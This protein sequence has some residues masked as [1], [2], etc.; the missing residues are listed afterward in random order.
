MADIGLFSDDISGLWG[1]EGEDVLTPAPMTRAA[2]DPEPPAPAP[3]TN[4]N[5][6]GNGAANGYGTNH[7]V[8]ETQTRED[9]AR[10]A[11]AIADSRVDIVR[12]ADL[13]AARAEMEGAF[14]QQ[15]AVALY[16]LMAA[17][18]AR[19]AA[20]EE[21]INQRVDQAVEVHTTRLSAVLDGHHRAAQ[22]M[23]EEISAEIDALR[24]RLGGP[25]DGLDA[26]RR[27]LRHE[28][29]RLS[30]LVMARARESAQDSAVEADRRQRHD[31]W[32]VK[33]AADLGGVSGLLAE[34]KADLAS[35]REEVAEL[36][37]SVDLQGTSDRKSRR[38]GR[39]R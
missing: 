18:N 5:G 35:L 32:V 17:S 6:N 26:F 11:Q 24:Q 4:G 7:A 38:W 3:A 20:A 13:E 31:D 1:S 30:D 22:A 15:L 25:I 16:E 23:S 2:D 27:D 37:A 29:G 19:F 12:P 36:R 28:V 10:L 33:A 8:V 14:T 34:M 39:S 9:V 21:H